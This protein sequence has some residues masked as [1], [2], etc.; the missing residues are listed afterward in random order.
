VHLKEDRSC[1]ASPIQREVLVRLAT[2]PVVEE[3]FFLTGGSALSIFYLHHRTSEDLDLFS[4]DKVE[5][6]TISFWIRTEWPYEHTII[7]SSPQ[8]LSLLVQEVRV[9]FVIDPL[10]ERVKRERF[11]W[12]SGQ[13]LMVDTI[14]NIASNKL[15]T[16][17]SRIEPKDFVDF[18]F[19]FKEIPKLKIEEV[20]AEAKRKEALLDDPPT[21]AYQLEEG[22]RF[23]K[24]HK[25]LIP[26]LK[27]VLDLKDLFVFYD[28]LAR[29]LYGVGN[30]QKNSRGVGGRADERW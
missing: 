23:L 19:L 13:S 5:L 17:V 30:R 16:L 18:Y 4:A 12:E 27:K 25:E 14:K 7:R 20:Y 29:R 26:P 2:N 8:F 15:C 10:S 11:G 6:S 28:N 3:Y 21:A 9:E 24:N 22:T 1:Y